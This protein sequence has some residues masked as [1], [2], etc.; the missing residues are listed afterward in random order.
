MNRSQE[1][2]D[3]ERV[4]GNDKESII[5]RGFKYVKGF[6]GRGSSKEADSQDDNEAQYSSEQVIQS[7]SSDH[8][9][10]KMDPNLPHA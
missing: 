9:E 1:S 4:S 5:S 3:D 6:F 10:S 2:R 7:A 8:E